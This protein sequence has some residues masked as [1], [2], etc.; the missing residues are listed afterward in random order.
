MS[1][2]ALRLELMSKLAILQAKTDY[3]DILTITAWMSDSEL[4][5]HVARY[6]AKLAR[7][8]GPKTTYLKRGDN[9]EGKNE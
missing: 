3:Q 9:R 4:A 8:T 2:T 6:S 5:D 1:A 7:T